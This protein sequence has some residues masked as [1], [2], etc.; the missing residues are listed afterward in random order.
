MTAFLALLRPMH[1]LLIRGSLDAMSTV[2]TV[3]TKRELLIDYKAKN[4]SMKGYGMTKHVQGSHKKKGSAHKKSGSAPRETHS[5]APP[6]KKKGQ[7][8]AKLKKAN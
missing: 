6:G 8:K 7:A 4:L 3:T 2:T 5:R 1:C